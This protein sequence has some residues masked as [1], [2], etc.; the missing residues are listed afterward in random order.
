MFRNNIKKTVFYS[1]TYQPAISETKEVYRLE[2]PLN[3]RL[4][5]L[6]IYTAQSMCDSL[7]YIVLQQNFE[8]LYP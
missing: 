4:V 7:T 5:F 8:I 2:E 3:S 1:K 6:L